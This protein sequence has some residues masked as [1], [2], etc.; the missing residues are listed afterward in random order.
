MYEIQ[1]TTRQRQAAGSPEGTTHR[2]L[3][4]VAEEVM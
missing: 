1:K 2:A 4:D 3:V